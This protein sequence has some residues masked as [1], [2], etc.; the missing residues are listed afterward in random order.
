MKKEMPGDRNYDSSVNPVITR[1]ETVL[2]RGLGRN[3]KL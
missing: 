3:S 1:V 2:A